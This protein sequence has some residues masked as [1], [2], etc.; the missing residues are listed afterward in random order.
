MATQIPQKNLQDFRARVLAL[1]PA[2]MPQLVHP[3]PSA[4]LAEATPNLISELDSLAPHR[5]KNEK[6]SVCAALWLLADDLQIAHEICQNIPSSHGSALHAIVHRR[7]G[8]FWNSN[9][10]WRRATSLPWRSPEGRPLQEQLLNPLADAPPELSSW[11]AELAAGRYDPARF[12]NLVEQHHQSSP[13]VVQLLLTAQRLEW[14][15]LFADILDPL[16]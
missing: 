9:Y 16:E 1:L 12:T 8:D 15:A 10:W 3:S 2:A 11:K 13:Q 5:N 4:P 6:L 7:E 14:A